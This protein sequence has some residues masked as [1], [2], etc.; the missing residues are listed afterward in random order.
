MVNGARSWE[1]YSTIYSLSDAMVMIVG[2]KGG[3]FN[4]HDKQ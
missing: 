4:L 1:A 2:P 3:G